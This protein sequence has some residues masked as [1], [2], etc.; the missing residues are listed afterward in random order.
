MLMSTRKKIW[1]WCLGVLLVSVVSI[2]FTFSRISRQRQYFLAVTPHF[3]IDP[4]KVQDF[5]SFLKGRFFPSHEMPDQIVLLS[6]NHFFLK[7]KRVE[8]LCT[9]GTIR[10]K[11]QTIVATP[12]VDDRI[13]C[14]G[15]VFYEKGGQIY[16]KDHGL[17][18]HF[19]WINQ[20][21]PT[22]RTVYLLA[23]PTHHM[24]HASWLAE[25]IQK[26]PWKTLVIASVD[27]S[28]YL[29]EV[30]AEQHDQVSFSV[31]QQSGAFDQ[32]RRLDVDCPACLGVVYRLASREKIRVHQR[33]RDSSSTIVGKD[34]MDQNTSRQFL[35]WE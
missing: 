35:R 15:G 26:L 1:F 8:G 12:F 19:R 29:S 13:A 25:N 23:L 3:M 11:D 9:F 7:Q 32:L 24:E 14:D 21:F 10:F 17:G 18:E 31:L 28:H 30:I 27:F 4:V 16:T 5:Y 34:L 2:F 6:P 33:W 20:F 22:V